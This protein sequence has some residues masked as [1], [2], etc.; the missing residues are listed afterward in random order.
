[1]RY[2]PHT[3]E[4]V[5]HMLGVI[6]ASDIDALLA[7]VPKKLRLGRPLDLPEA[8]SEQTLSRELHAMA[9]RNANPAT[10]DWFLGAGTYAHFTP[11]AVDALAS[12]AEFYTAYTPY[13]P[14]ISQGTLQVVFEWQSMVSELVGLPVANASMYDGASATAEAALMAMRV[15]RRDRIVLADGLHP[16]YRDVLATYVGGLG[17]EVVTGERAA[18]GRAAPLGSLVDDRTACVI[19]QQPGFLGSVQ[20]VRAI[21]EEAHAH[22]ALLIVT[23]TEAL[24]LALLEAPGKM[25]TDIVC[26]E[27]QSFGVPMSFGGPH[28]GFL[29]TAQKFLRQLPG[30]LVGETVDTEGRRGYVLTLST[31]E[32]HI[33]RERATSN[34]CTNQGLCLL[35]ATIYLSLHGKVG[36]RKLAEANLAKAEYA[37]ARVRATPGL[38]LPFP[39]ATFNE[40]VVGL[41]EPADLVLARAAE[42]KLIAGLDLAPYA[43]DLGPA[44]LV[45]TTELASREAIDRLVGLLAGEAS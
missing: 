1:M 9:E 6:G 21:A 41:S 43:S 14:E 5:R 2:I 15:T 38:S 23:T 4:D 34:I 31:R 25:G 3:E 42:A 11:S 39:A 7:A 27:A 32:Q 13:Q 30:R 22:G 36:L 18:D 26:G 37:K 20:D 33:R 35:L 8:T 40:F 12:R 17:A 29:A 24:S 28:L 19:L 45:C 16:H 44:L 10:H